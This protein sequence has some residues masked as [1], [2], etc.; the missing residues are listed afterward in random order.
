MVS[1]ALWHVT[2]F[3][4]FISIDEES[5]D[6]LR[7]E[8]KE[9]CQS[10][11][12]LGLVLVASEGINGTV[13]G[14]PAEI[15]AFKHMVCQWTRTEDIRF[16]DSTSLKRPFRRMSVDKRT[17]IVTLK[18]PDLVP[19]ETQN[20]H[21]SPTEWQE[22]LESEHPPLLIDT[23]NTYETLAGKFKGAIDPQIKHFSEWGAYLDKTEIPKDEPV[24][25]YCTGGIRCEKAILEMHARGFDKVYQ[26]RDGIIGYLAEFPDSK[27]EGEC[28]VFDD[29]VALDQQLNPTT[30]FGT[31]PGCGLTASTTRT[32]EQCQREY[33]ICDECKSTWNPVCSKACRDLWQRH[34]QK[35][36]QPT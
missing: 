19:N 10:N 15:T 34:T 33:W 2:S 18:R 8:I 21:L 28:Y 22:M 25:I 30:Q 36:Q 14:G 1:E 27:F 24:M 7:L 32:C 23:R 3:Y 11:G 4:R 12:I 29:R 17:E 16:K 13:G 9:W 20:Y 5:L 26:L 31:C 6:A 35:A